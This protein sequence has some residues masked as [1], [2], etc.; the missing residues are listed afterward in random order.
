[1]AG[2]PAGAAHACGWRCGARL[3]FREPDAGAFH[4]G[5]ADE[6]RLGLR[7]PAHRA[8]CARTSPYASS[9][10]LVPTTWTEEGRTHKRSVA[11]RRAANALRQALRR[12]THGEGVAT[13]YA[14]GGAKR[15]S[16]RWPDESPTS[17]HGDD[18]SQ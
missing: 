6:M 11:A 1:M 8:G 4:Q 3:T 15:R 7:H 18:R 12:A 10:R 9:G 14:A 13:E 2:P 5:T 16:G 17:W